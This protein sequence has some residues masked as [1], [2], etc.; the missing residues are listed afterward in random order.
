MKVPFKLIKIHERFYYGDCLFEKQFLNNEPIGWLIDYN[1]YSPS[2]QCDVVN[3]AEDTLVET[4][5]R[6]ENLK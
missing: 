6:K 4:E 1:Y 2:I 5:P 3:F